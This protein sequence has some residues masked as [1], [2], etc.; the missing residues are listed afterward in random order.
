[1]DSTHLIQRNIHTQLGYGVNDTNDIIQECSIEPNTSLAEL[2]T[3]GLP[4]CQLT[5]TSPADIMSIVVSLVRRFMYP[6][7]Q[8]L[9]MSLFV[10]TFSHVDWNVYRPDM[11]HVCLEIVI[12]YPLNDVHIDAISLAQSHLNEHDTNADEKQKDVNCFRYL[13]RRLFTVPVDLHR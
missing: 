12:V 6:F 3:R 4:P 7:K 5:L 2:V 1:M 11:C 8:K 13:I 10:R 9:F